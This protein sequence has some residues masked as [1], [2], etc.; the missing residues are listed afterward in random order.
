MKAVTV[1]N[2]LLLILSLA[3]FM[4]VTGCSAT[5]PFQPS[6]CIEQNS[7]DSGTD[8]ANQRCIPPPIMEM[9]PFL[10][11]MT[12]ESDQVVLVSN[13]D[14]KSFR[15]KIY[16]LEK[17]NKGWR[18]VF[19]PID[20]VIGKNGF[21]APGEKREGDNKVPAGIYPLKRTF[22]YGQSVKTKMPYQQVTDEDIW[23]DDVNSADYNKLITKNKSVSTTYEKM[24]RDD[25]LYRYGIVVE[26]NTKPIIKGYGSAIFFHVWG[27]PY[28]PTVGCIAMPEEQILRLF[29]WLDPSK[30]PIAILGTEDMLRVL[31]NG[32]V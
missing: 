4:V 28:I 31:L 20:A 24:K 7:R 27:G 15:A 2:W 13:T 16:L 8:A 22:G 9:L 19:A 17:H 14:P 26:Y 10:G 1:S 32:S 18:L 21:A 5:K 29:E 11:T 25:N 12:A 23:V 30:N 6:K 3:I